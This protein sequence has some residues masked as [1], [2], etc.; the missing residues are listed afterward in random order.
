MFFIVFPWH[1]CSACQCELEG[2]EDQPVITVWPSVSTR[3][4]V[5]TVWWLL[6]RS[7]PSLLEVPKAATDW[8]WTSAD[9]FSGV[10][11]MVHSLLILRKHKDT[12][13]LKTHFCTKKGPTPWLQH[14]PVFFLLIFCFFLFVIV[15]I[16]T[17]FFLSFELEILYRKAHSESLI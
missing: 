6:P 11:M 15:F 8:Y 16:F 9:T 2:A 10:R 4:C 12:N 13:F 14:T 5:I 17:I 1:S 7:S 3:D